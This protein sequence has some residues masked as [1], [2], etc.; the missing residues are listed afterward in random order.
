MP[1]NTSSRFDSRLAVVRLVLSAL[2]SA[3]WVVAGCAQMNNPFK[4]SSAAIDEQ[5]TTPSTEGYRSGEQSGVPVRRQ[6]AESRVVYA[7]GAVTHWPPWFE[8]PFESKGN[9]YVQPADRDAPDNQF[10]WNGLDYL[11]IGYSPGRLLVNI[12][13]FPASIVVNPPG[14]LM[15]SDGI[16]SPGLL[17]YDHDATRSDSA[18]R[19]PPDMD[20]VDRPMLVPEDSGPEVDPAA[21]TGH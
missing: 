12:A 11:D 20:N 4:D 14:T 2:V 9:A 17:G 6:W 21:D 16:L 8:D 19:E 7:N 15:E 18:T 13:G 3:A 1:L 5:M 10:A